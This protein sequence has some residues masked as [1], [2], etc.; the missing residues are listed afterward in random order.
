MMFALNW[1][2]TNKE[3]CVIGELESILWLANS[4][5]K[6]R[7]PFKVAS[8]KGFE[9]KQ[10]HLGCGGFEYWLKPKDRFPPG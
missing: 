6:Q 1:I 7:T 9:L 8:C 5:E 3:A 2:A 4:L 10:E